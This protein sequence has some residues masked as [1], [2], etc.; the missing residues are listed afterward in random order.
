M[1]LAWKIR[2]QVDKVEVTFPGREVRPEPTRFSATE[3]QSS[4]RRWSRISE[5]NRC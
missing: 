5:V 4:S 3:D 1:Q 2:R